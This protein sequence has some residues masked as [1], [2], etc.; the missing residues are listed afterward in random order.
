MRR[1]EEKVRKRGKEVAGE[2][3]RKGG[4]GGGIRGRGKG[5]GVGGGGG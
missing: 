3:G 2:N 5:E 4:V 1:K